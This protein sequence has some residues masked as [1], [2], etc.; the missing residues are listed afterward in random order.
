MYVTSLAIIKQ[1]STDF[2]RLL[3]VAVH[4]R[5]LTSEPVDKVETLGI[6]CGLFVVL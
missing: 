1:D 6:M 3:P 5:S 4:V 2:N